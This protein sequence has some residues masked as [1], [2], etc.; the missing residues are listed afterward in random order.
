MSVT[1]RNILKSGAALA[2]GM[3]LGSTFGL[4]AWSSSTL[5]MGSLK[6]DVLSDGNL[7][8]PINFLLPDV[9]KE[10]VES[11]FKSRKLSLDA[12]EPACNLTLVRDGK[13]TIIFDVGSG[14]NFMPSA[15]KISDAMEALELDPSEVTHV[16]FTH[17]HP[18]HLWGLLDDFDEPY[19]SE[20]EYMISKPEWDFW[21]KKETVDLMSEARKT[22]A[23]GARRNLMAIEDMI[24]RFDFGA[25][26]LPGI[27]AIDSN[28]HTPG[29][30]SFEIRVGSESILVTGDAITNQYYSF[31]KPEW[32]SGS[33]QDPVQGAKS[34]VMLLDRLASEKMRIVGFHLPYPGIG[35]VERA[36]GA[37]RFVAA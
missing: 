8:L 17:A 22:F 24:T 11:Y 30:A 13:R 19:F 4:P 1:R 23:V 27:Q 12:L 16:V 5:E 32:H 25:E 18:D 7:R 29:H 26:I 37:Y 33:D 6:L 20:A 31:E 9:P 21:I 2:G 14:P 28:G 3:A 35:M 34:R 15:G 10:E 36:D